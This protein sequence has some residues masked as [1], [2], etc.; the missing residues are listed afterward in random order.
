MARRTAAKRVQQTY[1]PT[2][3]AQYATQQ[4]QMMEAANNAEAG[5][6]DS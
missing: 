4:R 2:S 6:K 5:G 1:R 3:Y